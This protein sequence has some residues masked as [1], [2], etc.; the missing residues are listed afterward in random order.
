MSTSLADGTNQGMLS[1][2]LN[3][4]SMAAK[5]KLLVQVMEELESAR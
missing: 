3:A 5:Q 1:L 4:E 2:E